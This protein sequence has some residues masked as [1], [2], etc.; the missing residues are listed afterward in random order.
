M[1]I[2]DSESDR[3]LFEI[4]IKTI[5]RSI[6][7]L[8]VETGYA[9]LAYLSLDLG[10]LPDFIFLD[11]NMHGMTGLE[12]LAEIKKIPKLEKIPITMFTSAQP[13]AYEQRAKLLG[14]KACYT[15]SMRFEEN[16]NNIASVIGA[17]L[18]AEV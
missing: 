11:I 8:L 13:S 17:G 10:P 3:Q 15:K 14:A 2:D 7:C 16:V 1:F 12:C 9:A 18:Q 5:D 4:A 6:E